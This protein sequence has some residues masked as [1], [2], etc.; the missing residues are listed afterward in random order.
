MK[1]AMSHE[2]PQNLKHP[3]DTGVTLGPADAARLDA[4][5]AASASGPGEAGAGGPA[6]AGLVPRVLEIL[7]CDGVAEGPAVDSGLVTAT[8]AKVRAS[9]GEGVGQAEAA[10]AVTTLREDDAAAVD[11]VLASGG[12]AG[13]V[14]AGLGERAERARE[15]FQLLDR[16]RNA[17]SWRAAEGG[18]EG[19]ADDL[20]QRT[21][22]AAAAERQ[23]E[24][25]AQQVAM[26]GE[27]RRTLGVGWRQLVSAAAVPLPVDG[28]EQ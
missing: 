23:R 16:A 19:R 11:A 24:R 13:P 2:I 27:P 8:L 14:P 26:F 28:R 4:A 6:E 17:K 9:R 21:L 20:V 25:F 15:V 12:Q 1:I 3:A 10:V 5:L 18:N 22:A 7:A